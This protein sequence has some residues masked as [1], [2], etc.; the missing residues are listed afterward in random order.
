[1]TDSAVTAPEPAISMVAGYL[2]KR[3]AEADF[4]VTKPQPLAPPPP[5]AGQL[6]GDAS[7]MSDV[8]AALSAAGGGGGGPSI[9][10]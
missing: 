4:R 1:M 3:Q 10:I 5:T 8:D 2:W 6:G 9:A 7:P